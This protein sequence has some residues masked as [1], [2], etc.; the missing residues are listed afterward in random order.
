MKLYD[1][2]RKELM[3]VRAFEREGNTLV[4]K[5]KIMGA[6]PMNARLLPSEARAALKLLTPG[7][8]WFLLTLLF[9]RDDAKP[10]R[11]QG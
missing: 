9:R 11:R 2:N 6:M 4:I 5:G 10:E 1:S 8:V 7:L 3:T